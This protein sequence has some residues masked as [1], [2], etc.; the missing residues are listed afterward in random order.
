M[1]LGDAK[2]TS[3]SDDGTMFSA[4]VELDEEVAGGDGSGGTESIRSLLCPPP[5]PGV[6]DWGIPPASQNPCDPGVEVG[7]RRTHDAEESVA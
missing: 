4:R 5:I 6:D 2:Q 3:A 7:D 1:D